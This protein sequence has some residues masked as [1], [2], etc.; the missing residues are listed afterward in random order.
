MNFLPRV[1][2]VLVAVTLLAGSPGWSFAA[3][4]L[5]PSPARGTR[6]VPAAGTK[7]PAQ[8]ALSMVP[9]FFEENL[10]QS[11]AAVKF[12]ARAANYNMHLTA[13]EAV[14][15]LPAQKF[16][17]TKAPVVVRMK[18]K[19]ANAGAKASGPVSYTHLTLPT[20][21]IV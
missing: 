5:A 19:G 1:S 14:M 11:D 4:A 3:P 18:M 7:A 13:T 12:S 10:G 20:K 9:L 8:N 6:A 21:R 16:S 2:R 17:P 15:V